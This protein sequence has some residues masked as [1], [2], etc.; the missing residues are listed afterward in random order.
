MTSEEIK[1]NY[2]AYLKKCKRD[3]LEILKD[4]PKPRKSVMDAAVARSGMTEGE[5][6]DRSASGSLTVYR[7]IVGT[8][9]ADMK[10]YGDISIDGKETVSLKKKPSVIINEAEIAP[11]ILNLLQSHAMTEGELAERATVYFG[12]T[13]T[14][15]LDDDEAVRRTVEKLLPSLVKR[16]KISRIGGRYSI[17]SDM[18][19][20]KRPTSVLE[21][22][23]SFLNSK[24]GEFF[25]SYSAML[26]ERYFT[27]CG[28]TV[29][30][31]NV[32][33]GSDDGGIDVMLT[34]SDW[35]GFRDKVLVQ[36]KQKAT[37]NVTLNEVKQFV[38]AFYVEKGTKGIFMTTARFH[39]EAT[40]VING[41]RDIVAID[42]ERL[43]GISKKCSC[44]IISDENGSCS[45][46]Y[47]FFGIK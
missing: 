43:F 32:I 7:S 26:L 38:G 15:T 1:K 29:E 5:L 19:V 27:F 16:G 9:L 21:E 30:S 11:Y 37:A 33:G 2:K 4:G 17:G 41:L 42:G 20:M 10:K 14:L 6:K 18:I 12:A 22:F 28:K 3:I 44:G 13:E 39:R 25:E 40:S 47:G 8:A 24:G 46:D 36:C 35:L 34:V 23:I 31:C 45:V